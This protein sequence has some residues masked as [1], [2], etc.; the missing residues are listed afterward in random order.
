MTKHR[1]LNGCQDTD[2]AELTDDL[3]TQAVNKAFRTSEGEWLH[4]LLF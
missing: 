4:C 3:S 2:A 1:K